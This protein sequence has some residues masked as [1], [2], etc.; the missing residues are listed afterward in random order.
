MKNSINQYIIKHEKWQTEL[1]YLRTLLLQ[2]ELVEEIKWEVP[3][4]TIDGKNV[5]GLGTFKAHISLWFFHGALLNDAE[6]VLINA[7]EGKT[8]AMRQ[9]RFHSL[10]EIEVSKIKHYIEEAIKNQKN[11]LVIKPAK[12]KAA[13]VPKE[14]DN[15][16]AADETLSMAFANLTP[17]KQKEYAE[18][19]TEAK[20]EVTKISRLEKIKSMILKGIG[21]IDKYRLG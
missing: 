17:Y 3:V 2:T 16:L 18:Y 15:W 9:W 6:G 20:R 14:L 12:P 21:L 7:Q 13:I 4:Y 5:V 10:A 11:G 8:K 1:E 19:I